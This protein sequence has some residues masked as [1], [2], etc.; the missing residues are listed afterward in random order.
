VRLLAPLGREAAEGR[1]PDV[2]TLTERV[3]EAY[4]LEH[5][6]VAALLSWQQL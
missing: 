1:T 2:W 3:L 4:G 5:G 6:D